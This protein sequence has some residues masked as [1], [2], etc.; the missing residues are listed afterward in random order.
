MTDQPND[1]DLELRRRQLASMSRLYDEV[2]DSDVSVHAVNFLAIARLLCDIAGSDLHAAAAVIHEPAGLEAARSEYE[3][4]TDEDRRE[5]HEQIA[6]HW[7][8]NVNL[9]VR[10]LWHAAAVLN[11]QPDT[12]DPKHV[13]MVAA[14]Y[15]SRDP[16]DV[17]AEVE[18]AISNDPPLDDAESTE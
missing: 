15:L 8:L 5:L 16:D 1:D 12:L 14:T 2:L 13:A 6:E 3:H 18:A 7:S 17:V 11:F 9:A 4:L 10:K